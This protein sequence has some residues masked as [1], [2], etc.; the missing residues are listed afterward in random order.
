MSYTFKVFSTS[1]LGL[2]SELLLNN[3]V[4][5]SVL[6]QCFKLDTADLRPLWKQAS[7]WHMLGGESQNHTREYFLAVL[8][9][10]EKVCGLSIFEVSKVDS[11]CHLLKIIVSLDNRGKGLGKRL[12]EQSLL[13]L[14]RGGISK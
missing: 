5:L 8:L 4:L 6:D 10:D 13:C 2:K 11:F 7:I 9:E 3:Y 12:L 14:R 1:Q